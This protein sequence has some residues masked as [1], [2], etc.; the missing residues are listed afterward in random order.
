MPSVLPTR[1]GLEFF[2]CTEIKH[3]RNLRSTVTKTQ[4]SREYSLHSAPEAPKLLSF[5]FSL[6]STWA[7]H[8]LPFHRGPSGLRQ[9]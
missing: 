3:P 1:K 4:P 6:A 5:A 7:M 9:G 2:L 8:T